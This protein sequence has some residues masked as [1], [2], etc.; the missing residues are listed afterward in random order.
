VRVPDDRPVEA[1][2]AALCER[3][4]ARLVGALGLCTGSPAVAE[5][6]AQ[7][8]L[9]RAMDAGPRVRDM[10]APG[11][12]VH[13]VAMNLAASWFRRRAAERRAVGRLGGTDRSEDAD[14]AA[15]LT[16]R[17]AVARLPDRQRRCVVLRHYLGH[18][19]DV[20]AATLG[21][22]EQAV[23]SLT[24]RAMERLRRDIGSERTSQ[25]VR[26]AR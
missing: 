8:A 4:H 15:V 1:E 16:V 17:E 10:A 3:E 20:T 9:I 22:S 2:L 25:E 23:A 5:E 26:D 19:V 24:Y 7:E 18:P 12:W 11:A 6:L 13:R 21:I 14:V